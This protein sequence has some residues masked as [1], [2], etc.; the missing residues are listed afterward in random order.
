[1]AKFRIW[2]SPVYPILILRDKPQQNYQEK[3]HPTLAFTIKVE[4]TEEHVFK[5]PA[6]SMKIVELYE[7]W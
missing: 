1:M 3:L 6:V 4:E 2:K 5:T 7:M